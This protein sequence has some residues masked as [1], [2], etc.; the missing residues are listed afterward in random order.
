M[1]SPLSSPVDHSP[2]TLSWVK[3]DKTRAHILKELNMLAHHT[4]LCTYHEGIEHA[5]TIEEI[6]VKIETKVTLRQEPHNN[7]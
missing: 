1:S 2:K 7:K 5:G 6:K 4:N 3:T